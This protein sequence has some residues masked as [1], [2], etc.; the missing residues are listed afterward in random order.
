MKVVLINPPSTGQKR[1]IVAPPLGLAYLAGAI[2]N[3]GFDDMEIDI[4][5]AFALGM[6]FEDL[7]RR[8]KSARPDVVGVTGMSPIIESAYKAAK[9]ARP[10]SRLLIL[11]GAHVSAVGNKVFDECPELDAA[12]AGEAEESFAAFINAVYKDGEYRKDMPGVIVKGLNTAARPVISDPDALPFPARG[13]LPGRLYRHPLFGGQVVATMISSRGCPYNCIFCDKSVSGNKWRPRSPEKVLDEIE[14]IVKGQ[15]VKCIIFYD[16]LFTLDPDRVIAICKGIIERGLDITWKCEGRVNLVNEEMLEWMRKAGCRI[17][18]YGVETPH[19]QGLDFLRKGVK[20]G[21][22]SDAF[23]RTREAGI[24]TLAYFIMGIPVETFEE[25]LETINF[26]IKIK[27]DYAQFATL[28]PFPGSELYELAIEKGWYREVPAIGPGEQGLRRPVI[29]T[30]EWTEDKLREIVNRAYKRFYFR[31]GYLLKRTLST[32]SAGQL[33]TG[34]KAF[35]KL[36]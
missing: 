14:N 26:A 4:I 34:L 35:I 31:P 6:R 36:Q 19:Q 22:I 18:A 2:A 5:D 25:E 21:Q 1:D 33:I 20:A 24:E 11:G 17:I 23:T 9:I 15:G 28:S 29:I 13:L 27:A 32:R 10:H 30:Q 7:E 8:L 3:E 16:D 12:I